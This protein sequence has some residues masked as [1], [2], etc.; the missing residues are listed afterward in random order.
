MNSLDIDASAFFGKP[1]AYG[2]LPLLLLAAP[3]AA[4]AEA[5]D[6]VRIGVLAYR[7]KQQVQEQWRHLADTLAQAM[8]DR[9]F[10]VEALTLSELEHAVSDKRLDFVLTNPG[11]YVLLARRSGLSAPLATLAVTENGQ[12][13]NQFGGVV[14]SRSD[15]ADINSLAD[16][17]NKSLAVTETDAFG[18]Y[19]IQAYEFFKQGLALPDP[20]NILTTGMPHDKVVAAVMA[21]RADAGFV[22]TG[23]LESMAQEGKLAIDR[24]KVL[25]SQTP[26]SFPLRLSTR[27]YPEW[28]FSALPQVDE[29]LARHV[30]AALFLL[31]SN[32]TATKSLKIHG[33]VIAGDYTRVADMLREQ[34]LPP[35]DVTPDFTLDDVWSRY[36]SQIIAGSFSVV[37]IVLLGIRWWL[38]NR[39]LQQERRRVLQQQKR[40]QESEFRWKFAIEG[41]GDGLWDWDIAGGAMFFSKRWKAMLGYAEEEVDNTL[42]EWEQHIHPDDK[43]RTF[44]TMRAYI[45]GKLPIYTSEHRVRCR[46]GSWK[47]VLDRGMVVSRN[48]DGA[49]LRMI[50]TYS[51]ISERKSAE[52]KLQRLN[53][54]YAALSQC[55]Q[56]IVQCTGDLEL[57]TQICRE[58]VDIGGMKMA[59]IGL[60]DRHNLELKPVAYYGEGTEYLEHLKLSVAGDGPSGRGPT[61]I[62]VRENRPCWCQNFTA[63]PTT[64][65]WRQ[66]G[67]RFGWGASAALP[68]HR[69]GNVVGTLNLYAGESNAFDEAAR[70][71]LTEMATNIDYALNAFEHEAERKRDAAA[72]AES[73]NLLQTIID[74]VP[75]RIFWK[76]RECR[77]LGCNPAFAADAGLSEPK[78]IVGKDDFQLNWLDTANRY[79]ADDREVM[80]LKKPK[81]FYEEPQTKPGG[82]I[83]WLRSSKVPLRGENNEVIG[84]LGVYED[85]SEQKRTAQRIQQLANFDTLTGL[86]N[87]GKLKEY[88]VYALSLL[89]RSNGTL[90][91]MFLDLD[92]FKDINDSLGHSIGDELLVVLAKRMR[93]ILR[94][95]DT[96]SRLGGDEFILLLP[97]TDDRGAALVARKLLQVIAAPCRIEPYDLTV[98][99]SIGIALFP[100]DGDDLETL[101]KSADAAMY[102]VKKEGRNGYRF[103][104]REMQEHS[105]RSLRLANALHVAL[106]RGQL[107]LVY[108]PQICLH[109]NSIIGAE[110]L[111][112]WR[113]PDM[114][115]I[116]PAEFVP[117]AENNGLILPIGEWVLTTALQQMRGWLKQ[118]LAL[119]SVAVNLSAVQFRQ[120]GLPEKVARMLKEIG[121]APEKLEL[122]LT[123]GVAMHDPAGA[124]EIMKDIHEYGVRI[125]IDD[126]GTGYSSLSYLKQFKV[127][128]LKIDRSFVRDIDTDPEDR[129]I[130]KAIIS[131]ADSLGLN[132]IAEGV[133]TEAQLAFLR[134]HGCDEVQ[135]Y[136]FSQPLPAEEFEAF[137]IAFEGKPMED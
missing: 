85:I 57:F 8:P 30:A 117:L 67:L 115:P 58:A 65:P 36:Q 5:E 12:I 52:H 60:L 82:G 110:A 21:G 113:H 11:H 93:S 135:G 86:P 48:E 122:E 101:S 105:A 111:L 74:T 56:A 123:E 62:A 107:Q 68:L 72:L 16:L 92:H 128:K 76:D 35:F 87:R 69:G 137:A 104:T 37:L 6:T 4:W 54:L 102:R 19:R 32:E 98:T 24:I 89:K 20:K 134:D 90:A 22:R 116:S 96:V 64:E 14:F 99:A 39:Y 71:L 17:R 7:P 34:R 100:S 97:A 9:R 66:Q 2:L 53:Q 75:I 45:K 29:S 50:G 1:L 51:D 40:L 25:N 124:I 33:F 127:Y 78:E 31:E 61:G 77:Y 41:S 109:D 79:R 95:Q 125:S 132:T 80:R 103:F 83:V 47:W 129:A 120:P 27:L 73:R 133:E 84:V 18:G 94:E 23:V 106:E 114:G 55:N 28:P 131:L 43:A 38:A 63:D 3:A 42:S 136:Y 46:D 70:N 81:L 13:L 49:P 108:Q 26:A 44:A 126:F 118:Q 15:A 91:L 130:V 112:R 119:K 88:L 59:W 10:A 121:L